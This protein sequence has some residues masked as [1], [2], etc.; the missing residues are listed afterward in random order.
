MQSR[1]FPSFLTE[2]PILSLGFYMK[3]N[4]FQLS[5]YTIYILNVNK[6]VKNLDYIVVYKKILHQPL[7]PKVK[8]N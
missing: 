4:L 6:E 3:Q 5:N 8:I 2:I 7:V 1:G